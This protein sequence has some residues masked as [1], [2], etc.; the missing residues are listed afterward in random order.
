[1]L[2]K[3]IIGY[4]HICQVGEWKR[5]FDLIFNYVKN[6]GLYDHTS[7]IRC[8]VV[9]ETGVLI[10]DIRLQCDKFKIIYVGN[11]DAYERPTLLHMK[12]S[13]ETDPPNTSYWYLHTKGLRHFN[14]PKEGFVIDWIKLMLHWNIRRWRTA[15]EKLDHHDTYGCNEL[16]GVFYSGNFWWSNIDHIKELPNFIEEHYTAP[17]EWVLKKKDNFCSIFS[18]GLQGEGHYNNYYSEE[19]YASPEEIQK[20]LPNNFD[21]FI[22]KKN[23]PDLNHFSYEQCADHYITYGCNEN[24]ICQNEDYV[25]EFPLDFNFEYYRNKYEDLKELNEDQLKWHWINFG[26]Y[27]NRHY[28]DFIFEFPD[29]FELDFYRNSYEDLNGL[30]DEDL[31]IHWITKGKFE[32]RLYRDVTKL[33]KDFDVNFYRLKNKDISHLDDQSLINHWLNNGRFENRTYKDKLPANFNF[34][35]YRENNQDLQHL[36]DKDLEYHWLLYGKYEKR[37]YI[38][39]LPGDFDF[40]FYRNNH[41]DLK[42]MNDKDLEYHWLFYGKYENRSYKN[43]EIENVNKIENNNKIEDVNKI[44]NNNKIIIKKKVKKYF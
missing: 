24:R 9:N 25:D 2:H 11:S 26:K 8:G 34:R 21:V 35:F 6:Y 37:P 14:T 40:N 31:K 16:F 18:S 33:P 41:N 19:N 17:E 22:Y 27:E 4:F 5:S 10:D 20:N 43:D 38:D 12:R 39:K 13:S 42:S 29:D 32:N 28:K 15:I 3:N 36:S 1:M 30:S 7:E 44:E 23:N